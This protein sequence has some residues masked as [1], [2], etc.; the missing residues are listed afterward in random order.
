MLWRYAKKPAF[1]LKESPFKDIEIG[2]SDT[3]RAILWGNEQGIIK[4][5][6]DGTFRKDAACTRANVVTFLYRSVQ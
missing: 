4:G 2:T 1:T 5:Y 6:S 3:Q